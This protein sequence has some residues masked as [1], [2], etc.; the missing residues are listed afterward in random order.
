MVTAAGTLSGGST[1]VNQNLCALTTCVSTTGTNIGLP[2]FSTL[3]TGYS[4]AT[5][6]AIGSS[7]NEL[8]SICVC[9]ED[10]TLVVG[11]T[12]PVKH[13]ITVLGRAGADNGNWPMIRNSA[14]TAL[15]SKTKGFVITRMT[16]DPLQATAANHLNKIT[17]PVTGMMVFDV[18][19]DG[20]KGC[21][22]IYTGSGAGEGWKCFN[23]QACP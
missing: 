23:S 15:E 5:G 13:G 6:Q 2:Q 7:Q 14:Y 9:Y 1:S 11:Q 8:V 10:P 16:S 18:F 3:P 17:N 4:N 19:A 12:Y 20:G 22:K 21:L